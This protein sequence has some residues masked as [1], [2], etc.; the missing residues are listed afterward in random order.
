MTKSKKEKYKSLALKAKKESSDEETS[1][2]GSEDEEYAMA[3]RDF[4]KLFRRRGKKFTQPYDDKKA[5]R[6]EKL[7][8]N[9]LDFVIQFTSLLIVPNALKEIKRHLLVAL[10]AIV[11]KRRNSRR[12]RFVLW[13]MNPTSNHKSSKDKKGLG[14]TECETSTSEVKQVKFAKSAVN[15]ASDG[16]VSADSSKR[17]SASATQGIRLPKTAKTIFD[18]STSSKMDFVL[19][20]SHLMLLFRMLTNHP[21]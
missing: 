7:E 18:P 21:L 14:F 17:D 19:R 4:K 11:K 3:V 5:L 20:K 6:K 1:T 9:A 15:N 2:S 13:H 8:K 10:G 12:T 16:A